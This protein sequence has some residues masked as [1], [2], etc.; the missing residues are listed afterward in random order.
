VEDPQARVPHIVLGGHHGIR[1]LSC[2]GGWGE[3]PLSQ[4]IDVYPDGTAWNLCDGIIRGRYQ[5]GRGP[6]DPLTSGQ[7]EELVIDAG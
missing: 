5:K 6:A 1:C 7:V 2:K 4:L 3:G